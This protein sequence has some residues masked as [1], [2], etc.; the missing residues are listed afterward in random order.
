MTRPDLEAIIARLAIRQHGVVTRCQLIEAGITVSV[1][2]RLARSGRLGRLH[3]GVYLTGPVAPPRAR[4]MAA[5][6]ACGPGAL[7]SHGSGG[8][9]WQLWPRPA[10]GVPVE[11]TVPS[12]SGARHRR[13]IR[14]HRTSCLAPD[15]VSAV[16]GIPTTSPARTI[17]DLAASIR[18]RDL[19]QVVARAQREQLVSTE[20]L[21]SL[22]ARHPGR[23]G[24]RVLRALLAIDRPPALTRSQAEEQLLAAIRSADLPP[25]DLNARVGPFEI[26]FYWPAA[27][28]AVEVDGFAFHSSRGRFERDRLRDADLAARGI[29]VMR[30]TGR[31][32][33]R[34]PSAVLGRL[35][36]ALGRAG[37]RA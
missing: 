23:R 27:R 20:M 34:E 35:A 22:G 8:W 6:L 32:I 31:Q 25:P 12:G 30:V 14:V 5:V 28:F 15:D 37:A 18:G 33:A 16:D 29:Q 19:E 1:V 36:L 21:A 3:R 17:L 11:I 13:G 26:D 9:L 7:T 10:D 24:A 2:E 4:E